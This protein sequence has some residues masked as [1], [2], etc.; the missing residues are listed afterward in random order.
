M[1]MQFDINYLAVLAATV[2]SMAIGALW[3]SPILFGRLWTSLMELDDKKLQ[4]MKKKGKGKSYAIV[5][6]GSLIVS[7]VLA[8]F[9]IYA[10]A[11]GISDG[12]TLGFWVWI[13]Y[14]AIAM[15]G[16]DVVLW[17]G[18]PVKLYLLNALHY[19]V[20]LVVMGAIL[21]IWQ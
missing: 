5:F 15:L 20:T 12:I 1:V 7:Y 2:A 14:F 10:R 8:H 21:S 19:L 17:E 11:G 13:G 4:E 18:R 9:V 16:M 3:Y 6:L